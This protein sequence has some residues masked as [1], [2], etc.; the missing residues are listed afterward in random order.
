MT[1]LNSHQACESL[2]AEISFLGG[3]TRG[4]LAKIKRETAQD[5]RQYVS[6]YPETLS[7]ATLPAL[8]SG[9]I[10]PIIL[11]LQEPFHTIPPMDI[12]VLGRSLYRLLHPSSGGWE[13]WLLRAHSCPSPES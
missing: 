9:W 4:S 1:N 6:V 11:L 13:G 10:I 3:L 12:R 7:K 8:L 2:V 5:H